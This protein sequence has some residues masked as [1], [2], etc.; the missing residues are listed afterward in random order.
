MRHLLSHS[1]PPGLITQADIAEARGGG[2]QNT[3]YRPHP[4]LRLKSSWL[5]SSP[6]LRWREK[7]ESGYQKLSS[8]IDDPQNTVQ[9]NTFGRKKA[10]AS[11][12]WGQA[13]VNEWVDHVITTNLLTESLT[14]F[15]LILR[16]H[17][18]GLPWYAKRSF[19]SCQRLEEGDRCS[20][21]KS[22]DYL[23]ELQQHLRVS[24]SA[25]ETP[26]RILEC[27][28]QLLTAKLSFNDSW[29]TLLATRERFSHMTD[30][31]K[32]VATTH[33][34]QLVRVDR[35][36]RTWKKLESNFFINSRDFL[37]DTYIFS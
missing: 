8:A 17:T 21:G 26:G 11:D 34:W 36:E 20:I 37:L 12:S 35:S 4:S 24:Q 29:W 33:S 25:A 16:K 5:K 14:K 1:R 22:P 23:V 2:N 27:Q 19:Q 7:S 28:H 15:C 13:W 6:V 31:P 18:R 32:N 30:T 9:N 10:E 3:A